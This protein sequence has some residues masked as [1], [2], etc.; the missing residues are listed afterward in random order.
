MTVFNEL[1]I[2]GVRTSSFPF[3]IIIKEAPSFELSESKSQ[4]W[5]HSG[6]SGAVMQSNKHRPPI[7]KTY[8]IQMI[9]PTEE[10]LNKF[11][12]LL[13]RERFWLESEQVK[14]TRWWCYKVEGTQ[15]VRETSTV[16]VCVAT[17]ICHPTKFFKESNTQVVNASGAV[18][19]DTQTVWFDVSQN[20][21]GKHEV[22]VKYSKFADGRE[23]S[24][25]P[26]LYVGVAVSSTGSAPSQP[27]AYRWQR[28]NSGEIQLAWANSAD[29]KLDFTTAGPSSSTAIVVKNRPRYEAKDN[30]HSTIMDIWQ[31]RTE[32]KLKPNTTY[33]LSARGAAKYYSENSEDYLAYLALKF[34]VDD[35]IDEHIDFKNNRYETKS[36]TFQT[37]ASLS[38]N[39]T[40]SLRGLGIWEDADWT[41]LGLD[42][43]VLCEGTKAYQDYPTNEPA[44]V[45]KSRYL[46]I[47]ATSTRPA[48]GSGVIWPQGSALAYPKITIVGESASETSFTVGDQVIRLEKL[49]ESLVMINNPERPSFLTARGQPVKWSGDFIT[50]DTSRGQPVGV[51]LGPGIR[52]LTFE[53]VWGWA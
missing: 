35:P 27:S 45:M 3:Q 49:S 17:F 16:Y 28:L 21:H 20:K 19:R 26:S 8:T 36:V 53:T 11:M 1:I 47:M 9:E 50:V 29:G 30:N 39:Q 25:R 4:L 18:L 46:G 10:E 40:L 41:G 37:P 34:G 12:A 23:M 15:V 38:S 24:D 33:T 51:V 5:E 14:T 32:V 43:Y 31:T 52:S 13:T 22:F 7:K 42:W 48:G 6:I 44:Q 2:D